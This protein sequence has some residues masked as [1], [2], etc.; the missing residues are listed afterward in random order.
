MLT[1]IYTTTRGLHCLTDG[2]AAAMSQYD[3][4]AQA[5]L[6]QTYHDFEVIVVDEVNPLPRS[7]LAWFLGDR[8]RFMRPRPTPWRQQYAFAPASARN[9][10]LTWARGRVIVALDDCYSFGPYFL[11]R[12]A[13]L[14]D[15]DQ[16]PVIAHRPLGGTAETYVVEAPRELPSAQRHGGLIT[17]PIAAAEVIN[18]WDERFD[19]VRAREDW[20]HFDRLRAVGVHFVT[21]P[22]IYVTTHPHRPCER[23]ALRC[24]PLA[25]H[26]A[27]TRLAAGEVRGNAPWSDAELAAWTHC[28][29]ASPATDNPGMMCAVN[30]DGPNCVVYGGTGEPCGPAAREL[31]ETYERTPWFD[32]AVARRQNGVA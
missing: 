19:G 13:A 4:L 20:D 7:E 28:P 10:G 16:Y 30:P 8:V 24:I 15:R 26:L 31:I 12:I 6:E 22:A 27:Q 11:E 29:H 25:W 1:L 14:T 18:G 3:L 9:T 32:L 17:Y 5:L 23:R 2:P 21:D